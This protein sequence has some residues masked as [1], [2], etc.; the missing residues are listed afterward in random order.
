MSSENSLQSCR[1]H[2]N[3]EIGISITQKSAFICLFSQYLLPSCWLLAAAILPSITIVLPILELHTDGI[4]HYI[5]FPSSF[6]HLAKC[7][8]DSSI[9]LQVSRVHFFLLLNSI[10][11]YGCTNLHFIKKKGEMTDYLRQLGSK[12]LKNLVWLFW[13]LRSI[14]CHTC[15]S[16]VKINILSIASTFLPALSI[17][18]INPVLYA[19]L[20]LLIQKHPSV[21]PHWTK[22]VPPYILFYRCSS[23]CQEFPPL[24]C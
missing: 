9:F 11:L 19:H 22:Q 3:H 21:T 17:H 10:S 5:V 15:N 2:H 6:F 23:L 1:H 8:W 24:H 13:E 7:F 18:W 14:S 20:I 4:I 12:I 16:F